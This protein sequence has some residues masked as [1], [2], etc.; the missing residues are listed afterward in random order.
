MCKKKA[1]LHVV[2]SLR[3]GGAERIVAGT[4][5]GLVNYKHLVVILGKDRN[6]DFEL[7]IG[8][9]NIVNL[10]SQSKIS[11]MLAFFKLRIVIS[12]FKPDIIHS[13]LYWPTIISRL[14]TPSRVPLVSTYHSMIYDK[15][16]KAQYIPSLLLLDKITYRK[17]YHTIFVS[18]SMSVLISSAVGIRKN[19]RVVYNFVRDEFYNDSFIG[20]DLKPIR[21]VSIGNYRV[22]KNYPYIIKA[23]SSFSKDEI[24]LD[25]YGV[26]DYQYLQ[27]IIDQKKA[28]NI[29][30]HHG[31][32][33][34]V[35]KLRR[36]TIFI[37]AS[38][39][40]GF[41]I[42]L[43]EAMAS[44]LNIIV[45]DIEVFREVTGNSAIYFNLGESKSL[46]IIIKKLINS[47]NEVTYKKKELIS[48]SHRYAYQNFI[49]S[50]NL[51]YKN[52]LDL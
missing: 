33:D 29:R 38:T 11:Y 1:I 47:D 41:G 48:V 36:S 45:S 27:D 6:V 23:L 14:S 24:T 32:Q 49:D 17:K 37:M 51:T 35:S 20:N 10:N 44:G 43:A 28:S 39:H 46:E 16:N 31:I 18:N 22:E 42:A 13:H 30:L 12:R 19:K 50:M 7:S 3:A 34:V 8:K 5:N 25:I 26:G 2:D 40:E 21:A 9:S 4:I 52:I 15:S